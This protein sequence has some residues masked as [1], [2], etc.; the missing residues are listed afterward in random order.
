M[1]ADLAWVWGCTATTLL[2]ACGHAGS[3]SDPNGAV[4]AAWLARRS[5]VEVTASGSVAR[6]LGLHEGPS[7]EHEGFI[8]HLRGSAG[9]GLTVLVEDNV[10]ITGPIPLAPGD[11]VELRGE[12]IYNDLGGLIHYTHLDPAGHH[13]G[14]YIKVA[15]KTYM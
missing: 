8:L 7:G 11:D 2:I 13:P 5:H 1:R 12:Y 15:G 10:D 6:V 4:Y 14:G 3:G 9:H